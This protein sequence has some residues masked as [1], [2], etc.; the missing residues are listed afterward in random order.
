MSSTS[1]LARTLRRAFDTEM[2]NMQL[3]G[4]YNSSLQAWPGSRIAEEIVTYI[5]SGELPQ[6]PDKDGQV[7]E[8]SDRERLN[9]LYGRRDKLNDPQEEEL[10]EFMDRNKR[11][12]PKG[13]PELE[14]ATE[15]NLQPR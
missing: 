3:A 9:H 15:L 13:S 5:E 11:L 1:V 8:A 10:R 12:L 2:A 4:G 14:R 7:Q 6:L